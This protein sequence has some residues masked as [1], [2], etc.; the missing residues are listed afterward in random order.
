MKIDRKEV[1]F[2]V[3]IKFIAG[4]ISSIDILKKTVNKSSIVISV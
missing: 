1:T 3:D 2:I 4:S